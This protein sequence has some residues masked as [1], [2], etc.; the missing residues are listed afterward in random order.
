[1]L[2]KHNLKG[3]DIH[4]CKTKWGIENEVLKPKIFWKKLKFYFATFTLYQ[5]IKNFAYH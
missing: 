4:G 5:A 2:E 1:M 3:S